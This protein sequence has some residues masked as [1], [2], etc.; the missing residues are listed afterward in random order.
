MP[1]CIIN[2]KPYTRF[3]TGNGRIGRVLISL[4]LAEKKILEQPLL[5]ISAY[6]EKNLGNYYTGLLQISQKS[7][8]NDWLKFFMQAMA[9][10]ADITI[11]N[12]RNMLKLRETYENNLDK[13][14]AS[15]NTY[16]LLDNLFENPYITTPLAQKLLS[17]T[18]DLRCYVFIRQIRVEVSIMHYFVDML[19]LPILSTM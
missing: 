13:I 12:I 6:F 19:H 9:E 2:L 7:N 17:V 14:H 11:K 5:Y 8:W 10:Q 16:K 4:L 1:Q 3:K 15:K 18:Y